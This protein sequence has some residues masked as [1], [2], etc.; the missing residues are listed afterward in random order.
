MVALYFFFV[1]LLYI[2]VEFSDENEEKV[3]DFSHLLC[4]NVLVNQ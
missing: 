2:K 1:S 4:Y 3:V